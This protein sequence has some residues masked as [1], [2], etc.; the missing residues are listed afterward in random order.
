MAALT[1]LATIDPTT[2]IARC[3]RHW[4]DVLTG[5]PAALDRI[6]ADDVVMHSPVLFKP[7]PGKA[8]VAKYLT[9]AAMSFIGDP[10]TVPPASVTEEWDG[11]FRYVREVIGRHDAV[12]EFETTMSGAYVNGVDMIRC[13]ED[14]RIVDFKVMVRPAKALDAVRER[15]VAALATLS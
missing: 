7:L 11:R 13:D 2:P 15:M 6:L 12:L 9:A 5:D 1:T 10:A 3:L 4:Q 14:G 8:L